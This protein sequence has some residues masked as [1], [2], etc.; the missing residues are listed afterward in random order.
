MTDHSFAPQSIGF[1]VITYYPKWYSGNLRSIKHTDKVRGDLALEFAKKATAKG[2]TIVYV[3]GNSSKT[4]KKALAEISNLRVIKRRVLGR[5]ESKRQ[6]IDYLAKFPEVN[7]LIL[8]EPEKIS[9]LTDC[10]A[11]LVSP[12]LSGDADIVM[13]KRVDHLFKSSYPLYMYE[14]EIEC[15]RIYNEAL[16]AN[17]ILKEKQPDFDFCFGPRV[18]RNDKKIIALFKKRYQLKNESLLGQ[19]YDPDEYSNTQFFPIINAL[20]NRVPV[21][22]VP[23][24]FVYPKIQKENEEIGARD[25]FIYK[26]NLQRTS[27][28]IDLMHFLSFLK[29]KKG[30]KLKEVR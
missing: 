11:A 8:T 6:A 20:R 23:V 22:D 7:V 14:S 17:G 30:S 3:D 10:L 19:L 13:P 9:I 2:Y 16:R 4:F 1:A 21:C 5:S 28:L 25:A 27:L 15:N 26:R 12:I 18:F 29:K 24:P